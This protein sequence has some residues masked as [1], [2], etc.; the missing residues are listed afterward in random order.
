MVK[1][2]IAVTIYGLKKMTNSMAIQLPLLGSYNPRNLVR[3]ENRLRQL[4]R[5]RLGREEFPG[6]HRPSPLKRGE[7]DAASAQ[8]KITAPQPSRTKYM[9]SNAPVEIR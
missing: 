4:R 8:S 6:A 1:S 5:A 2:S 7:S 9:A 3:M